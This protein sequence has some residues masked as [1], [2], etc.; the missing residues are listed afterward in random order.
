MG[1]WSH[2]PFGNDDALDWV[3]GLEG[4]KDLKPIEEALDRVLKTDGY[5]E[6]P[7]ASQAVAAIE[8]I[9]KLLG[10]GTQTDSYAKAADEWVKSVALKP[11]PALL[12]K[13]QK[14]LQLVLGPESEL[15]E[16]WQESDGSEWQSSINALQAAVGA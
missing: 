12:G 13:A 11:T 6:A 14:A 1:A 15:R 3:D 4:T 10:R 8:V 9:A 16:L 5:L 7:E 2:Q